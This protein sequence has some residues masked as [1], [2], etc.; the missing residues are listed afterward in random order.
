VANDQSTQS[1]LKSEKPSG[2]ADDFSEFD[3][4][5]AFAEIRA[6]QGR[7]RIA[8]KDEKNVKEVEHLQEPLPIPEPVEASGPD[9]E[10]ATQSGNSV[11]FADTTPPTENES[12]LVALKSTTSELSRE[13]T[14]SEIPMAS[15]SAGS[16]V[17]M[18][19]S[20]LSATSHEDFETL[21]DPRIPQAK[22]FFKIGE[23][24]RITG[25]K[26]YVLRYWETEFSW[27]KPTKTSSRQR[28]YRRSDVV[29]LLRIKR[30]R[31]QDHHTIASA[32]EEIRKSR[33]QERKNKSDVTVG[34]N[35]SSIVNRKPAAESLLRS[36]PDLVGKPAYAGPGTAN[37]LGLGFP[38][39]PRAA[40]LARRL[41]E[42]RRSVLE[43]IEVVKE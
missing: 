11:E 43:I 16:T 6:D 40:E 28:M 10:L 24:S 21:K 2:N 13:A 14:D 18:S 42:M 5:R 27:V 32:R 39:A 34:A 26:P 38:T 22:Q 37:Q 8:K 7:D 23:V 29:M 35:K 30:L 36:S 33:K 12:E 15:S 1:S 4:D 9:N 19:D 25:L 41:S 31:Y 20:D 3:P 17:T